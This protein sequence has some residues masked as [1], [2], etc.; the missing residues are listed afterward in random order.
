[1]HILLLRPD[2]AVLYCI[3]VRGLISAGVCCLV[4]CSVAERS[5]EQ[6]WVRVFDCGRAT[7]S[8]HLMPSFYW[9]WTLKVPSPYC[10]ALY[11]RSF[12]LSPE[13]LSP[14]RSPVHSRGSPHLLPPE[15]A[16]FHSFYWPSGLHSCSPGPIPDHVTP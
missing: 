11:P 14:P 10:R 7:S 12:P 15:V 16:Y 13:S 9:R 4:G 6:W 8:L 2:Q 3:C 5:Q 1:V